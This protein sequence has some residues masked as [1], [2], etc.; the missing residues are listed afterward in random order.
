MKVLL[1]KPYNKSDHIQP[2]LGLGYLAASIRKSHDVR[3][4]DCIKEKVDADGLG[5]II[6]DFKPDV[7]GLQ[8]YTFD[9][10]FV[11]EALKNAKS[12][13]KKMVTVI[14]GPHP[15]AAAKEAM[16]VFNGRL[17][18]C[19]AGEAEIGLARLLE[20]LEKGN[21]GYNAIPGLVWREGDTVRSNSKSVVDDLDS[22]GMPAWDLIRPEEYPE[23]QH[24]AFFKNFPI[25]PIVITRGCPYPCTFCAGHTVSGK[26]VRRRSV[27]NVLEELTYLNKERG[28][29]EFLVTDDN[30]TLDISY[31]KEFLRRLKSL[32]LGMSWAVPNGVRMDSLDEELLG[33]MK[34]T[35][36][37]IISLGIESGSDRILGVMKKQITVAR[38]RKCVGMIHDAGIDISGFFIVGFPG[39]T[40]E[41]IKDTIKL[42]L[43]LPL[44]RA[45][46]FT[47]LPFPGSESYERLRSD[48]E[49]ADI[50]WKH[51][52]FMNASY[53]PKGMTRKT[54]KN[55]QRLAFAKFYLRPR[56]IL[57]NLKSIQ[58][59]RHLLFLIKRFF[60]WIVFN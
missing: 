3:I 51:F 22:L 45:N 55:L 23:S 17:D 52:Y 29:K 14:G 6:K 33:L 11:D 28:I 47:Y 32:G 7:L 1:V 44:V 39:E 57:Y 58:S 26:R 27:D 43:E 42:S 37:Y 20:S 56:V 38:I 8:C 10:S 16:D 4:L 60:N 40:A 18:F 12:Q 41:S 49:L 30:F 46:F 9:L 54:L 34:Q 59:F 24:G 35:G 5:K 21:G 48:N 36:L 19:F 31:A 25:A 53:T 13:N 15:S 2:S 50:D